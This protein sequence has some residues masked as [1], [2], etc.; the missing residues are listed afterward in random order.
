MCVE[1]FTLLYYRQIALQI[2]KLQ[3]NLFKLE[4]QQKKATVLH[5]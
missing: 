2:I 5:I 4:Q 3:F 1:V